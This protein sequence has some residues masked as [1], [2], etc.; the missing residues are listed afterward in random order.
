MKPLQFI[1]GL[2][3]TIRIKDI[4]DIIIVAAVFYKLFT[5]IRETRAEQLTKG[6]IGREFVVAKNPDYIFICTMGIAGE[7]ETKVW[8][9]YTSMNAV[10]NKHLYTIEADLACQPTPITFVETM[11]LMNKYMSE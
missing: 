10:K 2:F 8:K 9:S 1:K 6:I 7:Q 11:E 5:L 3:L 4:I